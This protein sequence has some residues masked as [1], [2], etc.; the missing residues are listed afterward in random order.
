MQRGGLWQLAKDTV[1]GFI[2]DEAL[3][4]IVR[5]VGNRDDGAWAAVIGG[6]A[7]ILTA[8]GVFGEVQSAL[9]AIWR[10]KKAKDKHKHGGSTLSR[11]ARAVR[12]VSDW[13]SPVASWSPCRLPRA[14]LSRLCRAGCTPC[15][16]APRRCCRWSTSRQR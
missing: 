5:K 2:D 10:V 16:P 4:E 12:P 13:S 14:P 3:E 1:T 15:F 7:L 11:L 8:T 9:N 6:G